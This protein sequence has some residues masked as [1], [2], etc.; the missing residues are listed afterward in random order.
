MVDSVASCVL[1]ELVFERNGRREDV[2]ERLRL[3]AAVFFYSATK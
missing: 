1:T 3:G 2:S